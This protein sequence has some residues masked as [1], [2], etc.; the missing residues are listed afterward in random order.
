MLQLK[1]EMKLL[2]SL[3]YTLQC[4]RNNDL[5]PREKCDSRSLRTITCQRV[6][7]IIMMVGQYDGAAGSTS[8]V[9]KIRLV[10][11]DSWIFERESLFWKGRNC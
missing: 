10:L 2:C 1:N 4:P 8:F 3:D 11:G 9:N 6:S 5:P 7:V